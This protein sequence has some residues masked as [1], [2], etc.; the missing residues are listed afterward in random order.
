MAAAVVSQSWSGSQVCSDVIYACS[1][2]AITKYHK[3]SG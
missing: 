2:A 3:L 1:V